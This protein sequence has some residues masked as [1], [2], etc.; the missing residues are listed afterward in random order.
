M[1]KY[2]KKP[3]VIEAIRVTQD[4]YNEVMVFVDTDDIAITPFFHTRNHLEEPKIAM[5]HIHTLEGVMRADIGD[6]VIKGLKG[7]FYPC[8]NDIFIA[9]YEFVGE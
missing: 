3:V 4:N 6:W 7:E 1:A 5:Y 8:K 2:R 9:T